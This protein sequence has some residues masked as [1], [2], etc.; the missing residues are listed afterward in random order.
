M[1]ETKRFGAESTEPKNRPRVM[2]LGIGGAGRN[3]IEALDEEPLVYNMKIY[4]VGCEERP[5]SLPFIN[6]SKKDLEE[7]YTSKVSHDLRPLSGSEKKLFEKIQKADMLYLMAGMGGE[8]GSWTTPTCAHLA[9]RTNAFTISLIAMPFETE[10]SR[11]IKFAEEAKSKVCEHS[12]ILGCFRNS[13]LLRL[14]PH[15][16]MTKAFDVMNTIIR[17]PME[18]FN[19]VVTVEDIRYLKKFCSGIDE[20]HIGAGYGKGRNRGKYAT[21]EALRSPWLDDFQDYSVVLTVVTSGTGLAEMEAQDALEAIREV[22]PDADIMWGLRKNP[23]IGDRTK[24][25]LLAGKKISRRL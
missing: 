3:I 5:S 8:I 10:N 6:V 15:L 14:N 16:P 21:K 2:A 18:D 22:T 17:L 4:E 19:A 25:T 1:A 24:V 23:D 7:A 20:F 9:E 12:D 13:R 11:R